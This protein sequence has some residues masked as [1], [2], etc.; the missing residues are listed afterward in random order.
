MCMIP[1]CPFKHP[2]LWLRQKIH[3]RKM[4]KIWNK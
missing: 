2:I 1:V 3:N 4:A